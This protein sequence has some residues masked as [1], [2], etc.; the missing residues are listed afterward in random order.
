MENQLVKLLPCMRAVHLA[1]HGM[2]QDIQF[3]TKRRDSSSINA[4][5]TVHFLVVISI[6]FILKDGV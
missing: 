4:I 3:T 1:S 2:K 5:K 6:F